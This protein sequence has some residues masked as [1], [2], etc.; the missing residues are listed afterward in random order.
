VFQIPEAL[1]LFKQAD[2]YMTVRWPDSAPQHDD[3]ELVRL[4]DLVHQAIDREDQQRA[5][6]A[7]PTPTGS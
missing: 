5:A 2:E 1:A 6:G 7:P 3:P 4:M